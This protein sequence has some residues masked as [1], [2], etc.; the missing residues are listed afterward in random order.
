MP[1]SQ[2]FS[3]AG[4]HRRRSL[5]QGGFT[6][7][8]L[9]VV[10]A[11]IG[12]LMGMI[13]GVG[14]YANQAVTRARARA[15]I[16]EIHNALQKYRIETGIYPAKLSDIRANLPPAIQSRLDRR[17]SDTNKLCDPWKNEFVY[18]HGAID[19]E[20]YVLYSMGAHSNKADTADD[21]YSGK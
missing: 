13:V 8:E 17:N 5:K 15:E 11:I 6:L 9:L 10:M 21:I 2:Q 4:N 18:S 3:H 16:Q 20:T 19:P 14:I 1:A 12:I 7:L